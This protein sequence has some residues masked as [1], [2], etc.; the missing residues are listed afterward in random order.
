M[1]AGL[2]TYLQLLQQLL[3]WC[4]Q[5]RASASVYTYACSQANPKIK[6][7]AITPTTTKMIQAELLSLPL[8]TGMPHEPGSRHSPVLL[9]LQDAAVGCLSGSNAAQLLPANTG[10]P[11]MQS[12]THDHH[13]KLII[14]HIPS[15]NKQHARTLAFDTWSTTTQQRSTLTA[16]QSSQL[17]TNSGNFTAALMTTAAGEG[18][19]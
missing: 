15:T 14:S 16:A 7:T 1:V 18:A 9:P 6:I 17:L 13:R 19:P 3:L 2:E 8:L 5:L 11:S 10:I 4:V 12:N